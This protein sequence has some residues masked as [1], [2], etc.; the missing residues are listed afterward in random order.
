MNFNTDL[1]MAS[2]WCRFRSPLKTDFTKPII[3]F[4]RYEFCIVFRYNKLIRLTS[5]IFVGGYLGGCLFLFGGWVSRHLPK[6]LLVLYENESCEVSGWSW[7][8]SWDVTF[9]EITPPGNFPVT[10]PTY[11][12]GKSSFQLPLK[13]ICDRSLEGILGLRWISELQ[14]NLCGWNLRISGFG[15]YLEKENLCRDFTLTIEWKVEISQSTTQAQSCFQ[16]PC[17]SIIKTSWLMTCFHPR[18]SA[19]NLPSL[20]LTYPLKNGW[21]EDDRFLLGWPIFRCVCC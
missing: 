19:K 15:F 17:R 2:S 10:Y 1:D 11:G 21:L 16:H 12:R 14:R 4:C 18:H 9:I 13:G 7:R 20:K 3:V 6:A 5:V 8:L